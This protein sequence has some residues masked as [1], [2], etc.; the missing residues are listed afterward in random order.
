MRIKLA[1][2]IL[3]ADFARLGE[4][5][6]AAEEAGADYIHVDIMDGHFVPNLTMGPGVVGAVR[7]V[8]S[9]PLDVHLMIESPD[10][11]LSSFVESGAS[12][13]TVHQEACNVHLHYLLSKIRDMG[14]RAGV[15]VNPSTP[16]AV[17]E[18]VLGLAD[19]VLVM[20]V[21]PGFGGQKMIPATI[22]KV[23]RL[24]SLMSAQGS[25]AE[26]EVDGGITPENAGG[27]V[28]AGAQVLVAGSSVFNGQA[29]VAENVAA[30]RRA[31]EASAC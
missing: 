8:T 20:T 26:I 17:L 9:L 27:L 21:N 7:R 5:V 2:S 28:A 29:S 13:I 31:I 16:I 24:A 12:T 22:E 25:R 18:E 10:S 14:V 6:R 3:S 19:L 11:L 15:A 30:L 23:R 1:P 4:Q